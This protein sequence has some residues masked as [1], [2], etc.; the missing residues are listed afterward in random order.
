MTRDRAVIAARTPVQ[1]KLLKRVALVTT[2]M[3]LPLGVGRVERVSLFEI[4][5][6][7]RVEEAVDR[8]F[9]RPVPEREP[10]DE[11]G[12]G[13]QRPGRDQP[14]APLRR[15][16]IVFLGIHQSHGV[17]PMSCGSTPW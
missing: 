15:P 14:F 4:S 17:F 2:D 3:L 13:H 1:T 7:D 10:D 16:R 6:F 12:D 11:P 9:L 8:V 5:G